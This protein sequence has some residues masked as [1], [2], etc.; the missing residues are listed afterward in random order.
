M[1]PELGILW[2][3]HKQFQNTFLGTLSP[4]SVLPT[5]IPLL[6]HCSSAGPCPR[7][8]M[9]RKGGVRGSLAL[10]QGPLMLVFPVPPCR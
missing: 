8:A 6:P 2:W 4:S 3:L 1:H 9:G 5:P 10:G 7:G